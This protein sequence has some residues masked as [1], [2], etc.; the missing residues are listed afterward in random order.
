MPACGVQA[1][2]LGQQ[3]PASVSLSPLWSAGLLHA[4]RQHSSTLVTTKQSG[5]AK[6]HSLYERSKC[7][8]FIFAYVPRCCYAGASTSGAAGGVCSVD[9]WWQRDHETKCD[10]T[11]IPQ[12]KRPH[13]FDNLLKNQM[14]KYSFSATTHSPTHPLSS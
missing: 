9:V 3:R 4:L 13:S 14:Y 6:T 10:P 7:A 12:V 5:A 2:R 1:I 11:M 8:R